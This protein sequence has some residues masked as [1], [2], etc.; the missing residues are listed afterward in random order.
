MEAA[1]TELKQR[2]AQIADLRR[3]EKVLSWD[4]AVWMPPSGSGAR[5]AQLAALEAVTHDRFVD[6]R[7]GEL[8]DELEPYAGSL[9]YDSD[10]ASLLRVTRRDWEKARRVPHALMS[11]LA[12][13]SATA[14]EAWVKAREASDFAAFR[15]F[16]ERSLDLRRR[17]VECF[18]PYDDPYDVL[19]DDYEP[20]MKTADIDPVFEQLKAALVPMIAAVAEA[21]PVDDSCLRGTFPIDAQRRFSLW[22]ME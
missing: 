9:P 20:G 12:E 5:G 19:L 6:D 11:E 1:L 4:L 15:P 7:I 8:L 21:E 2:L 16:L 13:N 14:Y 22:A 18:V 3:I 17:Y 10:D